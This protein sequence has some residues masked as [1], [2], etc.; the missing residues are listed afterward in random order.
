[1]RGVILERR[2]E[3][4]GSF[5]RCGSFGYKS[6]LQSYEQG[7]DTFWWC[8]QDFKSAAGLE[9]QSFD[10]VLSPTFVDSDP[11]G[12]SLLRYKVQDNVMQFVISII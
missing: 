6:W 7:Q 4:G 3:D 1:M 12:G 5:R 9:K 8:S 2:A 10:K 11:D